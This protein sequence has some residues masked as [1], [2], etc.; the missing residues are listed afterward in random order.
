MYLK[1]Q[2]SYYLGEEKNVDCNF[3]PVVNFWLVV[4]A[5]KTRLI[6]WRMI[7]VDDQWRLKMLHSE[8]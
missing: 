2:E 7:W 6:S 5:V 8:S 3:G 1:Q 4:D